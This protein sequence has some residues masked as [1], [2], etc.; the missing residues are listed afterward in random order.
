M[1]PVR[2]PRRPSYDPEEQSRE[3]LGIGVVEA[4]RISAMSREGL[5]MLPS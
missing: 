5:S 4:A 2:I 3:V 1:N